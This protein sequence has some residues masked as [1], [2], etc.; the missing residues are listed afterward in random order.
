MFWVKLMKRRV[1]AW[2]RSGGDKNQLVI[3]SDA[4]FDN[5]L[6]TIFAPGATA[7]SFWLNCGDRERMRRCG[8]KWGGTDHASENSLHESD[9]EREHVYVSDLVPAVTIADSIFKRISKEVEQ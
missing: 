8:S 4:R 1:S 5:E 9:F 6:D 2:L 3:F 7:H